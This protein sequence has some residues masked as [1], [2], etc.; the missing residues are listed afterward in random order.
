MLLCYDNGQSFSG[1][2][3]TYDDEYIVGINNDA[4]INVNLSF[5]DHHIDGGHVEYWDDEP[6]PP[7][8]EVIENDVGLVSGSFI[9][10][11]PGYDYETKTS[12]YWLL[13]DG[14]TDY[15]GL[16]YCF[17]KIEYVNGYVQE[18]SSTV[19]FNNGQGS[20]VSQD[21][22][23][24]ECEGLTPNTYIN[25]S[26]INSTILSGIFVRGTEVATMPGVDLENRLTFTMID[27]G[28]AQSY[29]GSAFVK[30]DYYD[31]NDENH[32]LFHYEAL[33]E[34]VDGEAL[35]SDSP[36]HRNTI[37]VIGCVS[38][39]NPVWSIQS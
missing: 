37:G 38:Y 24:I 23:S 4:E 29:T 16:A 1:I 8:G 10:S 14:Y 12:K 25:P 13:E 21:A 2:K 34:F 33:L 9:Y 7:S 11:M 26:F 35:G 3:H 27:E 31:I 30:A 5:G 19:W 6:V 28:Y 17:M 36:Y 18:Y 39:V 20:F 32:K 15:T 22:L